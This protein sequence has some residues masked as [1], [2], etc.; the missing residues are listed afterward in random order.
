MVQDIAEAIRSS[1]ALKICVSNLM[2]KPGESDSFKASDFARLSR[3][4][5]GTSDKL[6]CLIVNNSPF[7]ERL[8]SRY[9]SYGQAPV[10]T[11]RESCLVE[12]KEV[13]ER[14][15]LSSGVYIRHDPIPL[16]E[17][18]MDIVEGRVPAGRAAN[19]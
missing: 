11:D 18:I 1:K 7:P 10:E 3:E 12:A 6:D 8:L 17:T 14:P 13:V 19:P 2:T 16:A 4:Y 15:L 9:H 5:L